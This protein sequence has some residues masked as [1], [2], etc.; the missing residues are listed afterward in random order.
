MLLSAHPTFDAVDR[1]L[2]DPFFFIIAGFMQ[3]IMVLTR[4][5]LLTIILALI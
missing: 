1:A 2:F 4:D 5:N 3:K